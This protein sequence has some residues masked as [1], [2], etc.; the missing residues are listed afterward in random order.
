MGE[1]IRKFHGCT[2]ESKNNYRS[3]NLKI[4]I[5][6]IAS[7]LIVA[8]AFASAQTS[9]T[10]PITIVVDGTPLRFANQQPT[11]ANDRVLV[12]LRGIFEALGASVKWDPSTQTVHARKGDQSVDLTIGVLDASIGGQPVH[13][14]V[15]ATLINGS[16]MVPLRFVSESLGATVKWNDFDQ[17]ADITSPPARQPYLRDHDRDRD[18]QPVKVIPPVVIQDRRPPLRK[19]PVPI[20]MDTIA[21]DAVIPLSLNVRLSSHDAR[22]GDPFTATLVTDAKPNYWGLPPGTQAYGHVSFAKPK[23]GD[24][25]G[26]LEL[27]FD[28]LVTPAGQNIPIS[29]RL[30]G[31]EDKDV[32]RHKDG[33]LTAVNTTR[34][35]RVVYT[36][37]GAGAGL[38]VGLLS[39]RPIED[40][41]IG[42]LLGNL[43]GSGKKKPQAN[44]VELHPGI[45]FGFRLHKAITFRRG[46]R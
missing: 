6:S 43:L 2:F 22:P 27:T 45:R 10:K 42:G 18:R 12:P 29:G 30:I 11:K 23:R 36:G 1:A 16:T 37:A 28:R 24:D 21:E 7:S 44:D 17:E 35:D 41:A 4:Q 14:D 38:I 9:G 32:I 3:I 26:T 46:L 40:A 19:P 33:S 5:A 15:A 31:L 39:K 20:I 34:N 13:M 25:P 8:G